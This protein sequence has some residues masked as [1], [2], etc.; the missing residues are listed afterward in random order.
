MSKI[1]KI[2]VLQMSKTFH[3]GMALV[4][5]K[6]KYP[7]NCNMIHYKIHLIRPGC[8]QPSLALQCTIVA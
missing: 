7:H 8:L 4:V 5:Y 3:E 2:L 1:V 6:Q